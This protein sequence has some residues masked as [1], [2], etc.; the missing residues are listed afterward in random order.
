MSVYIKGKAQME[1]LRS[2]LVK[3]R[4]SMACTVCCQSI[5]S[6][7]FNTTCRLAILASSTSLDQLKTM[8][9]TS[10]A[11]KSQALSLTTSSLSNVSR[12]AGPFL[13]AGMEA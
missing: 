11:M 12:F 13:V 2:Q 10:L 3:G 9:K 1:Y 4:R 6:T 7:G 8:P 5:L